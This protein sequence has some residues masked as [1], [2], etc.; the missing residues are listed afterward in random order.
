MTWPIYTKV[1][2]FFSFNMAQ[3][4]VEYSTETIFRPILEHSL[5]RIPIRILLIFDNACGRNLQPIT[6]ITSFVLIT[7]LTSDNVGSK[8]PP[9][10]EIIP[11]GAMLQLIVFTDNEL[12]P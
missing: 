4:S 11:R 8:C 6:Q 1:S 3:Y 7:L 9:V 10:I 2:N 12:I 5:K